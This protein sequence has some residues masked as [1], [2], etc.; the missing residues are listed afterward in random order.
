VGCGRTLAE[1]TAWMHMSERERRA[2]MDRLATDK[3][4]AQQ[5]EADGNAADAR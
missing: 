2:V 5:H 4:L 3:R 1:I